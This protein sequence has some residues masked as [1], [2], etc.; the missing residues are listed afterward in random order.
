MSDTVT[1]AN[2]QTPATDG[3][4]SQTLNWVSWQIDPKNGR[5]PATSNSGTFASVYP[6]MF[7]YDTGTQRFLY[8]QNESGA[9]SILDVNANGTIGAQR[10]SG[11][12]PTPFPVVFGYS[13]S[14]THYWF[15]QGADGSWAIRSLSSDGQ[16]GDVISSGKLPYACS[17]LFSCLIGKTL[18]GIG[19]SASG[20]GL[21]IFPLLPGGNR[22]DV[23]QRDWASSKNVFPFIQDG[24]SYLFAV[25]AGQ[26]FSFEIVAAS[27]ELQL[28]AYDRIVDR[29]LSISD[30][31]LAITMMNVDNKV[32]VLTQLESG[33]WTIIELAE[34]GKRWF[35]V[36][37]GTCSKA[38]S[39]FLTFKSNTQITCLGISF[40]AAGAPLT[41]GISP[42]ELTAPR[43][44]AKVAAPSATLL[45]AKSVTGQWA[46]FSTF[47]SRPSDQPQ[48]KGSLP[49]HY[50]RLQ[51][52]VSSQN[53]TESRYAFAC[54]DSGA[55]RIF[56]LDN[57]RF[58]KEMAKGDFG[59]H[60]PVL[61]IF[62][63][64]QIPY[65]FAHQWDGSWFICPIT[66][67]GL[68]AQ[69][70]SGT[71]DTFNP[72]MVCFDQ[73]RYCIGHRT[74]G[75]YTIWKL[76]PTGLGNI[77]ARGTLDGFY[78]ILIPFGFAAPN[79]DIAFCLG[80]AE[81]GDLKA[82][83]LSRNGLGTT[84]SWQGK[85]A[86]FH[87]LIIPIANTADGSVILYAQRQDRAWLTRELLPAANKRP[88]PWYKDKRGT[89]GGLNTNIATGVLPKFY[90]TALAVPTATTTLLLLSAPDSTPYTTPWLSHAFDDRARP[91][92]ESTL[93]A[94]PGYFTKILSFNIGTAAYI[95]GHNEDGSWVI[96]DIL[97]TG[98]INTKECA[99]GQWTSYYPTLLA[100][101]DEGKCY[102][103]AHAEDGS[104]N[105]RELST[106]GT[107][108]HV[109]RSGNLGLYLPYLCHTYQD[110]GTT[111]FSVVN[112]LFC[113]LSI[114]A[115][116]DPSGPGG[117]GGFSFDKICAF[118]YNN[119]T[120]LFMLDQDRWRVYTVGG[121]AT[122]E[123]WYKLGKSYDT[124]LHYRLGDKD[125]V[126]LQNRRGDFCILLLADG[127]PQKV[128][129]IAK[130]TCSRFYP[131]ALGVKVGNTAYWIGLAK[132][133]PPEPLKRSAT[134]STWRFLDLGGPNLSTP[135]S[136]KAVAELAIPDS[137][138]EFI[139][140]ESINRLLA[141]APD[142]RWMFYET[143]PNRLPSIKVAE[144]SFSQFHG[145]LLQL[146]LRRFVDQYNTPHIHCLFAHGADGAY[147]VQEVLPEGLGTVL[148]RG[149]L[150]TYYPVV[151]SYPMPN[152]YPEGYNRYLIGVTPTGTWQLFKWQDEKIT[153]L[154]Q[155]QLDSPCTSMLAFGW[156]DK[157]FCMGHRQD[158]SFTVWELSKD[159]LGQAVLNGSLGKHYPKLIRFGNDQSPYALG[160]TESGQ[161]IRITLFTVED[162][163]RG[164]NWYNDDDEH[165]LP[166]LDWTIMGDGSFYRTYSRELYS[167]PVTWQMKTYP[168]ISNVTCSSPISGDPCPLFTEPATE[169]DPHQW[170]L[171]PMPLTG[172][173]STSPLI[174]V[175]PAFH[176]IWLPFSLNG[177]SYILGHRKSGA[178]TTFPVDSS[179]GLGA[180]CAEGTL[181]NTYSPT[182]NDYFPVMFT[183]E[184]DSKVF[185]FG[186]RSNG[187]YSIR[188]ILARGALSAEVAKGALTRFYPQMLA[189]NAGGKVYCLGAQIGANNSEMLY[190]IQSLG[191][192]GFSGK[193]TT[194]KLNINNTVNA[195]GTLHV[196]SQ[197]TNTYLMHVQDSYITVFQLR[198]NLEAP[199]PITG[200][201]NAARLQS[202]DK[203]QQLSFMFKS[204]QRTF[205]F[206]HRSTAGEWRISELSTGCDKITPAAA[207]GTCQRFY[208]AVFGFV[209]NGQ[210]YFLGISSSGTPQALQGQTP[211]A[212]L[213]SP[214][215]TTGLIPPPPPIPEP[216]ARKA[217]T[218][219]TAFHR[220]DSVTL[221]ATAAY[222]QSKGQTSTYYAAKA[223]LDKR[224]R[225]NTGILLRSPTYLSIPGITTSFAR[226]FAF[227]AWVLV[228][229]LIDRTELLF[230]GQSPSAYADIRLYAM[231][232]G[233]LMLEWW[234]GNGSACTAYMNATVGTTA[235]N[236]T[237]V[238]TVNEWTHVTIAITEDYGVL[239]FID[240]A[241]VPVAIKG[242]LGTVAQNTLNG[243]K[244]A[245]N[246]CRAL[247]TRYQYDA[248][249]EH[250]KLQDIYNK[251]PSYQ[252]QLAL[253]QFTQVTRPTEEARLQKLTREAEKKVA[254]YER[255]MAKAGG[256]LTKALP[257]EAPRFRC[258]F[259]GGH[260]DRQKKATTLRMA[261]IRLWNRGLDAHSIAD[262]GM[263][264]LRGDEVGLI[265]YWPLDPSNG[266]Q[267]QLRD[268]SNFG[269][270]AKLVG[271]EV[272]YVP[273]PLITIAD[274]SETRYA[275]SFSS[276]SSKLGTRP[277][278]LPGP[279]LTFQA[280]VK[281]SSQTSILLLELCASDTFWHMDTSVLPYFV[282]PRLLMGI[283]NGK[284]C[285]YYD[286][287]YSATGPTIAENTWT[288][289]AIRIDPEGQVTFFT[290]GKASG[291]PV[292]MRLSGNGAVLASGKIAKTLADTTAFDVFLGRGNIGALQEV[293]LWSRTLLDDQ[294]DQTTFRHINNWA[295][296][297]VLYERHDHEFIPGL[298][299]NDAPE[300]QRMIKAEGLGITQGYALQAAPK[301]ELP[302]VA[303]PSGNA[304]VLPGT[305]YIKDSTFSIQLWCNLYELR[306]QELIRIFD[307][308]VLYQLWNNGVCC[309][310]LEY[311]AKSSSLQV[312]YPASANQTTGKQVATIK[313]NIP[314]RTWTHI[315]VTLSTGMESTKFGPDS[316]TTVKFYIN[317]K[318]VGSRKKEPFWETTV[319][320][321]HHLG[322]LGGFGT[323]GLFTEIRAYNEALSSERI[324][325]NWY[326]RVSL[327]SGL[328]ARAA[329]DGN[330]DEIKDMDGASELLWVSSPAFLPEKA[331]EK[332]LR[333]SVAGMS[334]LIAD[335]VD[336][337]GVDIDN[338]T[339]YPIAPGCDELADWLNQAHLAKSHPLVP[340]PDNLRGVS[341]PR[342]VME[343]YAL[344][345]DGDPIP[346]A[347][348]HLVASGPG[349][350]YR[351]CV[352]F[353]NRIDLSSSR[354][355]QVKTNASGKARLLLVPEALLAPFFHVRH[356]GMAENEWAI[357]SPDQAILK[358]L[359]NISGTELVKGRNATASTKAGKAGLIAKDG[360]KLAGMLRKMLRPALAPTFEIQSTAA[361]S[362]SDEEA[363]AEAQKLE[364]VAAAGGGVNYTLPEGAMVVRRF[365]MAGMRLQAPASPEGDGPQAFLFEEIGNALTTGAE[366][367]KNTAEDGVEWVKDKAEDVG[368][369]AVQF[370]EKTKEIGKQAFQVVV[371]TAVDT[372]SVVLDKV[373]E[374]L[375]TL[376]EL[377][378]QLLITV[379][380]T[381]MKVIAFLT[382][383]FDWEQFLST[384]NFMLDQVNEAID[385]ADVSIDSIAD[386]TLKHFGDIKKMLGA[387]GPDEEQ[388]SFSSPVE[389]ITKA[390]GVVGMA[391]GPLGWLL[392]LLSPVFDALFGS[393]I[394]PIENAV[395]DLASDI[396]FF[397]FTAVGSLVSLA[398]DIVPESTADIGE[399]LEFFKGILK[400]VL[401]AA[402]DL[403]EG[404]FQ[405]VK[406]VA[407]KLFGALRSILNTR[408]D[409]PGVT[410]MIETLVLEGNSL[411]IGRLLCLIPAVPFT[412]TYKKVT[413]IS[414]APFANSQLVTFAEEEIN[415]AL[416]NLP[417]AVV[418]LAVLYINMVLDVI[419]TIAKEDPGEYQAMRWLHAARW[420]S[421]TLGLVIRENPHLTAKLR[422][423]TAEECGPMYIGLAYSGYGLG[424]IHKAILAYYVFK[425]NLTLPQAGSFAAVSLLGG[426]SS[427]LLALAPLTIDPNYKGDFSWGSMPSTVW[428]NANQN[429]SLT[430][431]M[432]TVN[433]RLKFYNLTTTVAKFI[434]GLFNG[435]ALGGVVTSRKVCGFYHVALA[436]QTASVV[437]LI[438][439]S[440]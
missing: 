157:Y 357:I 16:L 264:S 108:S 23:I 434:A 225:T 31:H 163:W 331:E 345:E 178:W 407:K 338:L 213:S 383:D 288:A 329:L 172:A 19:P 14:G 271:Q 191:S 316:V 69:S 111:L 109:L 9:Y 422:G 132:E 410:W 17:T 84:A 174:G 408:I 80:H 298:L 103:F 401:N 170:M 86:Q 251:Y 275:C 153:S 61:F 315:T 349:L 342:L 202:A 1:T 147:F 247:E 335:P 318:L 321:K 310:K 406:K 42:P 160:W 99:K 140:F 217:N 146:K 325:K 428:S 388:D 89:L 312:T 391:G 390:S 381:I 378:E 249:S 418:D 239:C 435:Q 421:K 159:G 188:E 384:A 433:D 229:A 87:P 336:T 266:G 98:S 330:P 372:F 40:S 300:G 376:V 219:I 79:P 94:L 45:E 129:E 155:G 32:R 290:G 56:L 307:S 311:V 164:S 49:Q 397:E 395:R 76:A 34:G 50:N 65:L 171:Q 259:G 78:P 142:G 96:Y 382:G 240:G 411:T 214:R 364:S 272:P 62:T 3:S 198:P 255:G 348:L 57:G 332:K 380:K 276:A 386:N 323:K 365:N 340:K 204:G 100:F 128:R 339:T 438:V 337:S 38:Y 199:K 261:D 440:K 398:K 4:D 389:A 286:A 74:D 220:L 409:I 166:R 37:R 71:L 282:I 320:R 322:L 77:M 392:G 363:P 21:L 302:Q 366:W 347:E 430:P 113:F 107:L 36:Q 368:E 258:V 379:A 137:Y 343:L 431:S 277:I 283:Q 396:A 269:R 24:K 184:A 228:S 104:W 369:A 196:F 35:E 194:G 416:R 161:Y 28:V 420:A 308:N 15:G 46:V 33:D 192:K 417:L 352:R 121:W 197:D 134:G 135:I 136:E 177:N 355:F 429:F 112:G 306:D 314:E 53:G 281:R 123:A 246:T 242:P 25:A 299:V 139:A 400:K 175:L 5:M 328:I 303:R 70:A 92:P 263:R 309:F 73:D 115:A 295:P 377:A 224:T 351:D 268:C 141:H 412:L 133:T 262:V 237:P 47:N 12:L 205:L 67:Q 326:K 11:Q 209:F 18:Y 296:D 291:P 82:W 169:S 260:T 250:R 54:Q 114:K 289:I 248:N 208:P 52:F 83:T 223:E 10:S 373:V 39:Q 404:A 285:V 319:Q 215:L 317:G 203:S 358:A 193:T 426:L 117:I 187:S 294:I 333:P 148:Q 110:N 167:T 413:G 183:F 119:G 367:V 216:A 231:A 93:G 226:G 179:K 63:S 393:L 72:S 356:S 144:G 131:Q 304:L 230:L 85:L 55:W 334:E 425:N 305:Y 279:G 124:L 59:E 138:Q 101:Q 95:L 293:R 287:Q 252:T 200:D 403:T 162:S 189:F 130:G 210:P 88:D 145:V 284:L 201:Q 75:R 116:K 274:R 254:D 374:G 22:G 168:I 51:S 424:I 232:N 27:N 256:S 245:L 152:T 341:T 212:S 415:P 185:W 394:S 327:Q 324:K 419:D 120:H 43:G 301:N 354:A 432:G 150:D 360:D 241:G 267:G 60:F 405:L 29:H 297:L 350:L 58:D 8:A 437:E 26:W 44:A 156:S 313:V 2:T 218:S 385:A 195:L 236:C 190:F 41:A 371:N 143:L 359:A 423:T 238:L 181:A 7:T 278:S 399:L 436:A 48:A 68:G 207:L 257:A 81:N 180:P 158:G 346:N 414:S 126:F 234:E 206:S 344:D 211:S 270:H 370:Y 20:R 97:S 402:V 375:D 30:A 127:D 273:H 427:G 253:D 66:P 173:A 6:T 265:G 222:Y 154:S 125:Y 280:W 106:G 149:K 244:A 227:Q 235:I 233:S 176:D 221:K 91:K 362:F 182:T 353:G 122:G 13:L 243:Y 186:Q 439:D 105:I 387:S 165:I 102:L 361:L 90:P 64:N 292:P 151:L 118:R